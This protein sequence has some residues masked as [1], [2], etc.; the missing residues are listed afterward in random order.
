VS[1]R[2]LA[3]DRSDLAQKTRGDEYGGIS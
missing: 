2:D 1:R 3:G